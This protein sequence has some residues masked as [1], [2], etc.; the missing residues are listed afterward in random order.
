MAKFKYTAKDPGGK[1]IKGD[2][3]A[4]DEKNAVVTLR[5]NSLV[6]LSITEVKPRSKFTLP[7]FGS[8]PKRVSVDDVVIFARQLATVVEAGVPLVNALDIIGEQIDKP[9]IRARV[10]RIRDDVEAG[11]SLSEAISKDKSFFSSFFVNM[12]KAGEASGTLDE[13][14]DRLSVYLE[15]SN[16]LQKKVKSALIYPAVIT[17]M[18]VT[19]TLV[20]I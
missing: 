6:I 19:I 12:V 8:G 14:L 18:A 5:A 20:L 1:T 9:D 4:T 17:G 15:K 3:E 11:L 16:D 7:S 2:V 13:I 10:L